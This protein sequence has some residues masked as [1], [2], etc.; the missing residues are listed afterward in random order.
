MPLSVPSFNNRKIDE[1]AAA[2]RH[3]AKINGIPVAHSAGGVSIGI[4]PEGYHPAYKTTTGVIVAVDDA[5]GE[6]RGRFVRYPII[7]PPVPIDSDFPY[8]WGGTEF[9]ARPDFG[10]RPGDYEAMIYDGDDAPGVDQTYVRFR[11]E[12]GGWI[13]ELPSGGESMGIGIIQAV[14]GTG[15]ALIQRIRQIEPEGQPDDFEGPFAPVA[16]EHVGEP[17]LLS[18]WPNLSNEHLDEL[19]TSAWST[20]A[21]AVALARVGG[22]WYVM[23]TLRMKLQEPREIRR[24]TGCE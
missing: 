22:K 24:V 12:T 3:L 7:G 10:R 2:V 4:E 6:L 8:E 1:L 9:R 23:Q 16:Y 21:V 20:T 15:H 14:T 18:T 13:A 11:R 19:V 5:A 17:E